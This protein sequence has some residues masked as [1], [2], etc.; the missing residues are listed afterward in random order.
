MFVWSTRMQDLFFST[1]QAARQLGITLATV[2]VLCENR[3]IATETTPGGHLRVYAS[4]VERLKRDG[5]PPIPRPLPIE[6]APPATDLPAANHDQI[7]STPKPSDAVVS[8][9]DQ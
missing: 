2:R 3:L 6:S 4:E 5:L 1:G 7:E 9:A 8:A